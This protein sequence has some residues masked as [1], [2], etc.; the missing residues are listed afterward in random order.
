MHIEP[1]SEETAEA[2]G[3]KPAAA[4]KTE[5]KIPVDYRVLADTVSESPA[6]MKF[7]CLNIPMTA[8]L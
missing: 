8:G 6:K 5:D 2:E 1:K 7:C 4:E 3:K